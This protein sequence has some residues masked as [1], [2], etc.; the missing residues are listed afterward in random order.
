MNRKT[1][2]EVQIEPYAHKRIVV[3]FDYTWLLEKEL[4]KL[5]YLI[6]EENIAITKAKDIMPD[7]YAIY[8]IVDETHPLFNL[9]LLRESAV[10]DVVYNPN[11]EKAMIRIFGKLCGLIQDIITSYGIDLNNVEELLTKYKNR[12]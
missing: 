8:L 11:V 12:L 2:I 5:G 9:M 3:D 4:D 6:Q 10:S 1:I 7:V